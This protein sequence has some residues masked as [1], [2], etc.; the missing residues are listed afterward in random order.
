MGHYSVAA[1]CLNGHVATET[2]EYQ[3]P[4]G[5]CAAC[6]GP[7]IIACP[8]CTTSIR[9]Y[10]NVPG[11]IGGNSDYAPPAFCFHCGKAFP[12]TAEKLAAAQALADELE[13]ISPEDR[14]KLKAALDDVTA[15]GPRSEVG[16]ARIKKM[17]GKT[18]T[19]VGQALW[20]ICVEV[21]GEAA[22]KILIGS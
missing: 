8:S 14:T 9:G 22:K 12:W 10:Y 2:I 11:F 20:K 1:I 21:A 6:G 19:A 3:H 16:A 17:L 18:T 5:F 7:I 13:N 15:G 4:G